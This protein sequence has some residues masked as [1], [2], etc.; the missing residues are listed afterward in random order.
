MENLRPKSSRTGVLKLCTL[1]DRRI[2]YLKF[3]ANKQRWC[4]EVYAY[5]HW[6]YHLKPY[7]PELI[8]I[9]EGKSWQ[10]VLMTSLDGTIM[11]DT[12]LGPQALQD[13][14]YRAGE[15]TRCVHRLTTG[16]WFG[17]MDQV[18]NPLEAIPCKD[19]ISYV[20]DSI[21]DVARECLGKGLLV[22][23]EI[24]L[25]EWALQNVEVFEHTQPVPV[26][27]D[28]TP[29]NWLVD[30]MGRFMGMIDFEN[31]LWGIDVDSFSILF[32]R[33]FEDQTIMKSF[34]NGYGLEVLEEKSTHIKICCIKLGLSNIYW[35]EK[36]GSLRVASYG[37]TLL[38]RIYDDRL[39]G[40]YS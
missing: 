12:E 16:D 11:R 13:A 2:Y 21:R 15:L 1:K 17:P 27:W 8:H 29:G 24:E 32:E 5:K 33:Y 36:H 22:P 37:K 20:T 28:S 38:Q 23:S 6:M 40:L 31:M 18:G 10:A 3:Y 39:I 19:P 4:S 30:R 35:G 9:L 26:N 14:Y 34:F 25:M 7:A